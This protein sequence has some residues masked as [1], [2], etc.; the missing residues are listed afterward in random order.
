MRVAATG[1]IAFAVTWK[2]CISSAVTMVRLA[3]AALAAEYAD[4]PTLP[5]M[6]APE[7]VLTMRAAFAPPALPTARQWSQACLV[8]ENVP[9]R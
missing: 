9:L 2:R 8:I 5:N 6:P 3:M 4:W 1:E 7:V